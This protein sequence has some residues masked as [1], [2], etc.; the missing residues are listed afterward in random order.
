MKI[1]VIVPVYN[2]ELYLKKCILSVVH[3][4][5]KNWELIL[6]DDGSDDNSSSIIQAF[7]KEDSRIK[8]IWQK[9]SGPGIARNQGICQA[10]G[11][12]IVFL[13]SDDYLDLE[14]FQYLVPKAQIS[15]V[16]FIDVCQINSQGKL[17]SN[18]FMSRYRNYS[19]DR[20]IRSQMTGK[21]PW[22]GVRK[23]VRTEI[24]KQNKIYYTE[25]SI[26]EEALY[27]FKVLY[28]SKQIS[29][30][31]NKPVYYY[32][33]HENSQSKLL[34]DDPWGEAVKQIDSFL[35]KE[36]IYEEYANTLNSFNIT[37]TIISISNMS[38]IYSDENTLNRK[39]EER[40]M[41]CN[42]LFDSIYSV[43]IKNMMKKTYPFISILKK[44]KYKLIILCG[45]L[46]YR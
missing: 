8:S 35:K 18:E 5:Y 36:G 4:S 9:N 44:N 13:D 17:L 14:Y 33:N 30:L 1:S 32:V 19:K 3:Q 42:K 43:D 26:G 22:G 11:E 2:A 37:S 34:H 28:Y 46:R 7:V 45:K 39:C 23:A 38:K 24:I 20:L 21:I 10:T 15:D 41:Q 6:V 16:V 31:E 29:F 27:S 12:Y 25:Q 40:I